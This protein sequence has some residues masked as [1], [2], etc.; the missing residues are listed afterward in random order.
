MVDLESSSASLSSFRTRCC[1]RNDELVPGVLCFR[2]LKTEMD[3]QRQMDSNFAF[4]VVASVVIFLVLSAI[5]F[6]LI[7]R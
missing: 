4:Y 2:S 7:P 6:V 5:Q 3:F 1:D